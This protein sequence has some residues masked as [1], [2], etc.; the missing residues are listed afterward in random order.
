MYRWFYKKLPVVKNISDEVV[1]LLNDKEVAYIKVRERQTIMIASTIG[2]VMV[3][4]LYLPQYF[5][6]HFFPQVTITI[7]NS[8][9]T[10]KL[11]FV[12]MFYG[13]ILVFVEIYLLTLLHI[14]FSH[15][16]GFATGYLNAA[17]RFTPNKINNI[18]NIAEQNKD[19]SILQL[20]INPYYGL[21]NATI[22]LLNILFTL[23]AFINNLLF[24]IIFQ[25]LLGR[26]I[27]RQYLDLIGIPVYS[28]WNAMATRSILKQARIIMMGENVILLFQ[29]NIKNFR[30]LNGLEKKLIYDA[31]QYIA[32]SKRDF[33]KNHFLLSKMILSEFEIEIVEAHTINS[34]FINNLSN[35][36]ND[37]IKLV[38][39]IFIIGFILDGEL[40]RREYIRIDILQK[41]GLFATP[42]KKLKL[43]LEHFVYGKGIDFDSL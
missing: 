27:I 14:Y 8:L 11:S 1:Y 10:F 13:F 9:P 42:P 33:H 4:L 43:I 39:K 23:K 41:A 12:A 37:F 26:Y 24:K 3:L 36:N 7:N 20:G 16:L 25:R 38:E 6:P 19:K 34:D 15:E 22:F 31:L 18:V 2:A 40:S 28:F 17:N 35:Q 32:I 30:L 21:H 5:F 29:N